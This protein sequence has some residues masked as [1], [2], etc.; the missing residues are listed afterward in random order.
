MKELLTGNEAIARGAYENGVTVAVGYP[1]TPSTEI[2]E[3]SVKYPEIKAQWSPN[4][5][6]AMEVGVGASIGGA[7]VVVT[8]KHVGVNVAADPLFTFAYTGVNGGLVLIS[9]DD[10]GM[11]SSQNEQDNRNYAKFAKVPMFEPSD[12]QECKDMLGEA[13]KV[14][15]TYDS[16]VIIRTTTRVAHSQSFVE[17][18]ERQNSEVKSYVKDSTKYVMV[19]AH[20]RKRHVIVEERLNKLKIY[21]EQTSFN[22][23][24]IAS[25]KVGIITSGIDYQYVKEALPQASVLKLG[26]SFPLP[27]KLI[28]DFVA[29]VENVYIVE[30][31]EPF[32]E[33]QIA[34]L[35]IHL[36]GKALFS[37]IGELSPRII[38]EKFYSIPETKELVNLEYIKAVPDWSE[39]A[40]IP[41]RPPVLCPGCPHRGVFYTFNKLKL[42]VMGD[43]GCYTLGTLPPLEAVDSCICMGA[44]I[45]TALGMQKAHPELSNK[46]VSVI[47]DSTFMHSGITGLLDI[48]YNKGITTTVILDNRTTAMTGHQ[49]HPGT[50]RTLDKGETT[51][52]DIVGLVK[53]L[54]VKRVKV[55][56]PLDLEGL[57]RT[58]LEETQAEEPS[59]IIAQRPC[60][61]L[62]KSS[63]LALV[64]ES[65]IC[66][67]CKKCMK[68]GCPALVAGDD[69]VAINA[70]LC[71]GCGLCEQVCSIGAIKK[72]GEAVG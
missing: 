26:F 43:I 8:M 60:A 68:L 15:E 54:G 72:E 9:A 38:A 11:H 6:V 47:G 5:K 35:G 19:P 71:T 12:S 46:I 70:A 51:A 13:L 23:M 52:I 28:R 53:A 7:R 66:I 31:L 36:K 17:L 27:E 37:N 33:E 10:P 63:G 39:S 65:N 21:S 16:P 25:K 1:G 45:G 32:M 59:V 56:D 40:A 57:K 50:G 61:L 67:G 20:A 69:K 48:V 55:V 49:D 30:E 14:S 2:L 64:I 3:N 24:E 44:S 58:L 34:Y 18:G 4:E 62:Q 22:R 42:I 41:V 29:E